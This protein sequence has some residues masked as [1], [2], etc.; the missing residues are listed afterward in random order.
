MWH[1]SPIT[2]IQDDNICGGQVDPEPTCT[3][4]EQE[5]EFL[6]VGFVVLADSDYSIIMSSTST[7]TAI[8][9]KHKVKINRMID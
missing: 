4:C 2:V 7:D 3:R 5:N 6:A 9:C 8:F 1:N